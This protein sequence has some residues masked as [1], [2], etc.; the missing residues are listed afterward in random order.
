[1]ISMMLPGTVC[2]YYGQEIGM[3]NGFITPDQI[4]DYSGNGGR[5]PAR[6]IMQWDDSSSAGENLENI[7]STSLFTRS[8][9]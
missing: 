8:P 2:V 1:M 6:L 5:D 7:Y 4:R 3:L 9:T